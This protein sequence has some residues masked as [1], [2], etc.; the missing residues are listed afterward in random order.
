MKKVFLMFIFCVSIVSASDDRHLPTDSMRI[1]AFNRE[2]IR[3]PD[4]EVMCGE[5]GKIVKYKNISCFISYAW[6]S[7]QSPLNSWIES[8][9]HYLTLAG[10]HI[11]FDKTHFTGRVHELHERL[12]E[13][14]HVLILL[15][16]DYRFKCFEGRSLALE[17]VGVFNKSSYQR[18]FITLAGRLE[19]SIP[20]DIARGHYTP[21]NEMI[22]MMTNIPYER[23]GEKD[24]P[25]MDGFFKVMCNLLD[26]E[27]EWGLLFVLGQN[28]KD[29]SKNYLNNFKTYYFG[30]TFHFSDVIN[31]SYFSSNGERGREVYKPITIHNVMGIGY[32]ENKG[33]IT[34]SFGGK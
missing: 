27:K 17:A 23:R 4:F 20:E 16:P 10:L 29:K 26:P 24:I 15:T 30:E 6:P 12:A 28:D 1:E 19:N 3:L 14:Q 22:H 5:I 31:A 18:R 25:S 21:G 8:I 7:E 2:D 33:S 9:V 34:M 32:M 11:V 13:S